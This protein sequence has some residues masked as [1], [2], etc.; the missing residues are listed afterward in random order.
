MSEIFLSVSV[1]TYLSCYAR[2][3]HG[4]TLQDIYLEV[5]NLIFNF[6]NPVS[7]YELYNDSVSSILNIHFKTYALYNYL[8][9]LSKS[10]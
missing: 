8:T 2:D 5:I 9:S 1:Q 6:Y 3:S 4:V 7:L 10:D